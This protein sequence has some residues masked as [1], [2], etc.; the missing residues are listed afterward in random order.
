V[1]CHRE[2]VSNK[3]S[4]TNKTPPW[5]KL[6]RCT[7]V[8]AVFP[9]AVGG[10]SRAVE[11][12]KKSSTERARHPCHGCRRTVATDTGGSPRH[13]TFI[14]LSPSTIIV[15]ESSFQ[16]LVHPCQLRTSSNSLSIVFC[17]PL[18]GL[19]LPLLVICKI[20]HGHSRS[21]RISGLV[22]LVAKCRHPV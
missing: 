2:S 21:C 17:P 11:N 1:V 10:K 7:V 3:Y 8:T 12:F 15:L 16:G 19:V 18:A 22:R 20:S 14:S 9:R 5:Y 13:A 6:G 4:Q